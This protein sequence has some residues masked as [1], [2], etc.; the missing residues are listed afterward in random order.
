MTTIRLRG[1]LSAAGFAVAVATLV[2]CGSGSDAFPSARVS[3]KVTFNNKPLTNGTVVVVLG[4]DQTK[5]G[6][7]QIRPDGTYDIA[8][9]PI[10]ATKVYIDPAKSSGI[11]P[12]GGES[13]AAPYAGVNAPAGAKIA[14]LPPGTPFNKG[15]P[16][17][18]PDY[19]PKKYRTF[20]GTPVTFDVK[21]GQNSLN[22]DM[23]E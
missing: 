2:G 17:V 4:T 22:I 3:G 1:P 6:A 7:G 18:K 11:T 10:G 8:D 14:G 9:A 20:D 19:V 23:T 16:N 15:A 13:S 21:K 5:N 12:G